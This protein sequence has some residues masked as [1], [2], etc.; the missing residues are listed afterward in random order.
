MKANQ[1]TLYRQIGRPFQGKRRIPFTATDHENKHGRETVWKLRAKEAPEHIK[2]N[3]PG[4][5]WIVE[6]ITDTMTRSSG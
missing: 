1:Q 5:A 6:V 2:A 3:W 4:S